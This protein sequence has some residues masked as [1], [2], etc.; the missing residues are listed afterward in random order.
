M[1]KDSVVTGN[2]RVTNKMFANEAQTSK[3]LVPT[4]SGDSTYGVGSSGQIPSPRFFS[5]LHGLRLQ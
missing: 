1:L 2:L 5:R 4:S 3:I